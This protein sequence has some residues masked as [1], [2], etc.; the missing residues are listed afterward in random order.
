MRI[1]RSSTLKACSWLILAAAGLAIVLLP[2]SSAAKSGL[3]VPRFVSLGADKANVRNGP[4]KRYPIGWVF[5]RR[6]VPL[7]V[8][9]E[10]ELWRKIRDVDG[11][12]GWIHRSL[13]SNRRS[14]SVLGNTPCP[15]RRQPD[16]TADIIARL[17]PGVIVRLLECGSDWCQLDV[18][19]RSGWV[20]RSSLWGL[21]PTE[22]LK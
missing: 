19:D 18:S 22:T 1:F 6:G 3:P 11:A 12:I 4:G 2:K 20:Q 16:A 8:V 9:A 13:L 15:L 17:E 21:L 10:Y 14:A 7:Q 5:V